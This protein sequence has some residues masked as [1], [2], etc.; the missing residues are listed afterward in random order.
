MNIEIPAELL[1]PTVEE[2]EAKTIHDLGIK[3][4]PCKRLGKKER[5][6]FR[7]E[8][9]IAKLKAIAAEFN[10]QKQGTNLVASSLSSIS[11]QSEKMKF[12]NMA[13]PTLRVSLD[14]APSK[15]RKGRPPKV[16]PL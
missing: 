6:A 9:E 7:Q 1:L 15:L 13:R 4:K 16:K 3:W 8:K 12:P 14:E 2:L 11:A 5:I 10:N